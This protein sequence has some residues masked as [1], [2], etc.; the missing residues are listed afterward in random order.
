V[1]GSSGA[2]ARASV[3]VLGWDITCPGASSALIVLIL[4]T[5]ALIYWMAADIESILR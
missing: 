2:A 5:F 3:G 1:L 4:S